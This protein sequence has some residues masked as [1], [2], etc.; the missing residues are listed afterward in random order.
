MLIAVRS[1]LDR[2]SWFQRFLKQSGCDGVVNLSCLLRLF[3]KIFM[4]QYPVLVQTVS[5]V[6]NQNSKGGFGRTATEPVFL[7]ALF[8]LERVIYVLSVSLRET[9]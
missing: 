4:S 6:Q 8:H 9:F 1:R 2:S 7:G 3:G 5:Q